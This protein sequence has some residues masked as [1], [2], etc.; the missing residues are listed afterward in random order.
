MA[1]RFKLKQTSIKEKGGS[2]M[3][4]G[5]RLFTFLVCIFMLMPM[6]VQA[7]EVADLKKR[8][9][10]DQKKLIVIENIEFTEDEGKFFWP[11]YENLQEELFQLDQRTVKLIISYASSPKTCQILTDKKVVT[12][13]DEY[14][15]IQKTRTSILDKYMEKLAKSLPA[16]KV[17]RYL[18]IEN[19]LEAISRF[20]LAKKIPLCGL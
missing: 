8:I 12:I 14:F 4:R 2:I 11:V 15:D 18:Q 19:K 7:G 1:H 13:M 17:F 10:S 6:L 5:Q 16:Q 9:M 20:D 3:L